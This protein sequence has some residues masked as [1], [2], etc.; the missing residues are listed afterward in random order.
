MR[1]VPPVAQLGL[2]VG[3]MILGLGQVA[4][5]GP[6]INGD[7]SNGL[8]GWT[9]SDASAVSVVLGAAVIQEGD[10]GPE[11]DMYQDFVIPDGAETLSFLLKSV[12]D[13]DD[14]PP[15]GFGASLLDPTTLGSLVATVDAFTDSFYTRDLTS[16]TTQGL[17]AAGVGVSPSADALPLTITLDVSALGGRSARILFRVI[18]GG[19]TSGASATLDD[20]QVDA[21]LAVPEPGSVVMLA[22]GMLAMARRLRHCD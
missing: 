11:V 1:H 6:I 21:P 15:S 9:V 2:F 7:I 18:G 12:G 14:F 4:Q 17:A 3:T 20:V 16:G 10:S 13:E 22:A 8:A 19:A 5:A